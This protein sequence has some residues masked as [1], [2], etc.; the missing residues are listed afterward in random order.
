MSEKE[1]RRGRVVFLEEQGLAKGRGSEKTD[2]PFKDLR[3]LGNP[4]TVGIRLDYSQNIDGGTRFLLEDFKVR[5]EA[6]C[7]EFNP[8]TMLDGGPSLSELKHVFYLSVS[9]RLR[10]A[11]NRPVKIL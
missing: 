7:A 2:F 11:A 6:V 3:N 4:V 5:K 10:S 1:N 9:L 8:R